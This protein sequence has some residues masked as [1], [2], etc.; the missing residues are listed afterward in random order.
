MVMPR[1]MNERHEVNTRKELSLSLCV[2]V[3]YL[4]ACFDSKLLF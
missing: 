3:S 1:I 2:C 4:N